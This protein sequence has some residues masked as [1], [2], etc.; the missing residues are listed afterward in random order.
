MTRL[1]DSRD[2]MGCFPGNPLVNYNSLFIHQLH[3]AA[4]K[5]LL[6]GDRL[7]RQNSLCLSIFHHHH[8]SPAV[9]A[10]SKFHILGKSVSGS[11]FYFM[12]PVGIACCQLFFKQDKGFS[13]S[14]NHLLS[15]V[16]GRCFILV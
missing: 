16:Q 12:K 4:G 11:R 2:L 1:Q 14:K 15:L 8:I 13:G 3:L 7:F 10:D 6:P 9:S 5:L